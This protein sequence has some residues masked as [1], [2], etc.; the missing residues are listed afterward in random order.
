MSTNTEKISIN[1]PLVFIAKD[2]APITAEVSTL[3]FVK[4]QAVLIEYCLT[5]SLEPELYQYIATESL[6]NL[7]P[8]ILNVSSKPDFQP[9]SKILLEISLKSDFLKHLQ[10]QTTTAEEAT[11]CL[12]TLKEAQPSHPLFFTENWLAFSVKQQQKKGEV[13]YETIWAK[14]SPQALVQAAETGSNEEITEAITDFFKTWTE[15][16]LSEV[17]QQTTAKAL[18]GFSRFFEEL[19]NGFVDTLVKAATVDTSILETAIEFLEK[20][21]WA[22]ARIPE[23]SALRLAYRGKSGQWNCYIQADEAKRTLVFY[24]IGPIVSSPQL[25]A[26]IAEFITRANYGM[27]I[28]NFELDYRDGEIR[29][30]TSIDVEGDRLTPALMKNLVYTNVMTL[31]EYLPGIVAVV[32]QGLSPAQAIARVERGELVAPEMAV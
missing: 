18:G 10:D 7:K 2:Y 17:A 5:L 14:L 26:E 24:S 21:N 29:Y 8:A 6:F 27:V 19:T 1:K 23:K 13:G 12:F 9:T 32:E 30:K 28:G 3:T 20:E 11:S 31:D 22:Y 16:K 25:L 4:R 15:S